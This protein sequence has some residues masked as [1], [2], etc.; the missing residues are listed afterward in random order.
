MASPANRFEKHAAKAMIV[1][2]VVTLIGGIAL[3]EWLLSPGGGRYRASGLSAGHAPARFL[4]MREWKRNTDY[5]FA[6]LEERKKYTQV[7]VP[8]T[9]PIVTDAEGFI[10]PS[11][12]HPKADV[13]IVFFGGSTTECAF[14]MPE[15]RFAHLSARRLEDAL[16]LKINGINA[17]LSGNNSMHALLLLLGKGIPLKPDFAV[18]MEGINDIGALSNYNSYWIKQGSIRILD[19]EKFTVGDAGRTF[20]KALVPNTSE[21]LQQAWKSLRGLLGIRSANAAEGPKAQPA[22]ELERRRA[23]A[24]AYESS[25]RSFARVAAAWGITPVFMTQV[26]VKPASEGQRGDTF[27]NRERL[28]GIV[29]RP[30]DFA[31]IHDHFNA[32][33]REVA[34]SENAILIDLAR[35][36]DWAFGDVYDA[37]HFTDHGSRQVADIVAAA[38]KDHVAARA[39]ATAAAR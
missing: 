28:T 5:Q 21:F 39:K 18:L 11:R 37:V 7:P 16:G 33:L 30:E 14:V 26:N 13:N 1:L 12:R 22:G 36:R 3:V 34:K 17:G 4:V 25:L 29:E 8:K 6:P 31:D 15:N 38:L 35:A 27:L 10:E 2:W 23:M 32:I 24:R 9:Y 19:E 20:V